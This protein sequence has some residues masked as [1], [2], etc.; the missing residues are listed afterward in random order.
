MRNIRRRR[1]CRFFSLL[2]VLIA[3]VFLATAA[4]VV[5]VRVSH[6]L[7]ERRFKTALGRLQIELQSAHRLAI[8]MQADW[9]VTLKKEKN[10]FRITRACPEMDQ[11]FSLIWEASCQLL[12]EREEFEALEFHFA[13]TGKISPKGVLQFLKG[14]NRVDWGF[15]H[16][17]NQLEE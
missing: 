17:F 6:G 15:P 9:I 4:T 8:N 2:E 11:S 14:K 1:R 10:G 13:A 16:F 5:G 12:W 7:E 3:I